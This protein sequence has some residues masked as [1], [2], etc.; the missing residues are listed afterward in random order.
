MPDAPG[1]IFA[2]H[3]DEIDREKADTFLN[4]QPQLLSRPEVGTR[5]E[6]IWL[7]Q[8]K[9]SLRI[10]ER[11]E[12]LIDDPEAAVWLSIEAEEDSPNLQ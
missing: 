9:V 6:A 4:E 5:E 1:E 12:Y 8:Q 11:F 2:F 3:L 10:L 7:L